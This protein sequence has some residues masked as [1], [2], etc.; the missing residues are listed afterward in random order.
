MS[1]KW[2][3]ND[4]VSAWNGV[5]NELHTGEGVWIKA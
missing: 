5:A 3:R 4:A 1:T 2:K